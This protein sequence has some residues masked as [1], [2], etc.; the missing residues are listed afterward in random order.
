MWLTLIIFLNSALKDSNV[1]NPKAPKPTDQRADYV[2]KYIAKEKSTA[3]HIGRVINPFGFS[4]L[5]RCT[6]YLQ[7]YSAGNPIPLMRNSQEILQRVPLE[8][9]TFQQKPR[10]RNFSN[11]KAI[12]FSI[13]GNR[14]DHPSNEDFSKANSIIGKFLTLSSFELP[15]SI[16]MVG[17]VISSLTKDSSYAKDTSLAKDTSHLA[18]IAKPISLSPKSAP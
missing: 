12:G 9:L 10:A 11:P 1:Y 17:N 14:L 15:L 13:M 6:L 18:T 3:I 7:A 8:V 16:E 5:R 4:I 2:R